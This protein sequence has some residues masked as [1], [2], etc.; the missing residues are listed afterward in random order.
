MVD[1]FEIE[2][3]SNLNITVLKINERIIKERKKVNIKMI[4]F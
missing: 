3:F 2:I 1:K 4:L